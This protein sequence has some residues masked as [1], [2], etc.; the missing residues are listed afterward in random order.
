MRPC[1]AALF[2]ALLAALPAVAADLPRA[3]TD[4]DFPP[5][6]PAELRLGQLLF[7]DK[8]LS[9]N[10]NIS[11][12]TCHHPRFG[13][14]DGVS[15]GLGE[16]GIGLGPD[17]IA[18]PANAPEQRIARNAPALWNLGAAGITALFH[19][20]RIEADPARSSGLRTPLEDEM[21]TGFASLLAAQTMFPVLS[22]DEMAGHYGENDVARAVRQGLITG[23]GGA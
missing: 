14:S 7:W 23:P 13:T 18:D 16:G 19:D 11:C 5:A 4:A 3:L 20:G 8:A 15:L 6:D 9:G 17:R 2:A 1:A 21:V 22:A 10:R 12:G